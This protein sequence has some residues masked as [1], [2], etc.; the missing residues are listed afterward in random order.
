M[1]KNLFIV[2]F[3]SLLS[4]GFQNTVVAQAAESVEIT[5]KLAQKFAT[6]ITKTDLKTH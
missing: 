6:G 4:F 1:Q 3:I 5:G 2:L